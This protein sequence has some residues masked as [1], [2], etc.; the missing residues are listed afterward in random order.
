MNKNRLTVP[1]SGLKDGEHQFSFSTYDRFFEQFENSE[2]RNG[3]A[4]VEAVLHKRDRLMQFQ[5]AIK[6]RVEVECDLCL[7]WFYL[8]FSYKGKF[9]VKYG[10]VEETDDEILMISENDYEID[11]SQYI[12]ESICLSLPYTKIHPDNNDGKSGCNTEMIEKLDKLRA[13]E[14]KDETTD[15]R[16]DKLNDLIN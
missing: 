5:V 7:E 6:G 16:W 8:P 9:Y 13:P 4:S 1:F 15:P 3:Q 14:E 10:N 11:L 12:Y 2:I